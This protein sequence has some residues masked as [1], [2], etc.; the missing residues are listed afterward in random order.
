M[1]TCCSGDL[2]GDL[3]VQGQV[4]RGRNLDP[5]IVSMVDVVHSTILYMPWLV[6]FVHDTAISHIATVIMKS[7]K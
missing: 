4:I 6:I 3:R 5:H 1:N 2:N 7:K